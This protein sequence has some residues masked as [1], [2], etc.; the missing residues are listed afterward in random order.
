MNDIVSI[1]QN[2]RQI[3]SRNQPIIELQNNKREPVGA[4]YLK[5]INFD[6]MKV[7]FCETNH[8]ERYAF[9]YNGILVYF[10][11]FRKLLPK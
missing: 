10:T 9:Y 2:Y 7:A 4:I 3:E 8:N 6:E 5:N 1:W 11:Y